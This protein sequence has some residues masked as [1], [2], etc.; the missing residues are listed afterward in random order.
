MGTNLGNTIS[1]SL[2]GSTTLKP[3]ITGPI[4]NFV[5][6]APHA[7]IK[8]EL[9]SFGG[10]ARGDGQKV[11]KLTGLIFLFQFSED[12]QIDRLRMDSAVDTVDL[13]ILL[14]FFCT[15]HQRQGINLLR[16]GR[17]ESMRSFWWRIY[18]VDSTVST[19]KSSFK[20][21]GG[22]LAFYKGQP[23]TVGNDKYQD[24]PTRVE[25]LSASGWS[26]LADFPE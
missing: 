15:G 8:G 23:T 16:L 18:T 2:D 26:S 5:E 7:L 11:M 24:Q 20:H 25:T 3:T 22:K 12:W 14:V 6:N 1:I 19:H 10:Q 13:Q 9:F 21:L 17:T 4:S